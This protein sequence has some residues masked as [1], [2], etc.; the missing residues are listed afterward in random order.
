MVN[1]KKNQ[2]QSDPQEEYFISSL[3]RFSQI[4]GDFPNKGQ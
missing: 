1:E 2:Q 4:F 3:C